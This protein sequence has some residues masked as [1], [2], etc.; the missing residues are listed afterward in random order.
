[1]PVRSSS[2]AGLRGFN[3]GRGTVR[4]SFMVSYMASGS[5]LLAGTFLILRPT[6]TGLFEIF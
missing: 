4:W 2:D 6:M 5:A 1:M 3:G